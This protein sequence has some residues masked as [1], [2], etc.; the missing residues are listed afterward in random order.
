M[1]RFVNG[2][3]TAIWYSQHGFGAAYTYDAVQ[4]IGDRPVSFSARGSH[5]N[6]PEAMA[7][8]FHDIGM[9]LFHSRCY[10]KINKLSAR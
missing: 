4:K 3:P 6:W 1:I 9:N 10:P 7:H 8:D 5:S 2:T